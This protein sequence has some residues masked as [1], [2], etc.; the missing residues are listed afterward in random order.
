M[1]YRAGTKCTHNTKK[2]P[3]ASNGHEEHLPPKL[4]WGR[5]LHDVTIGLWIKQ[6]F[7]HGLPVE[8]LL[9]IY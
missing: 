1:T 5:R 6:K 3:L 8:E 7:G 9:S 2:V 4:A